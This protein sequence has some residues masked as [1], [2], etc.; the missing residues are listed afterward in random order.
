MNPTAKCQAPR[1]K[2][3]R[4]RDDSSA[5]PL[6]STPTCAKK[7]RREPGFPPTPA[8]SLPG[9]S[10]SPE[11]ATKKKAEK[12][13]RVNDALPFASTPAPS[14]DGASPLPNT[15]TMGKSFK[16]RQAANLT[17]KLHSVLKARAT[18]A[19][20]Q[21]ASKPNRALG[22]GKRRI[23]IGT[24]AAKQALL[25]RGAV[26]IDASFVAASPAMEAD[27]I[28]WVAKLRKTFKEICGE[29][30]APL[31]A[32]ERWLFTNILVSS[33][34]NVNDDVEPFLAPS[35][36]D[37]APRAVLAADLVRGSIPL[38]KANHIVETLCSQ[39]WHTAKMKER[40][41]LSNGH[42]IVTKHK[43]TIDVR[44]ST[45]EQLL[46]LNH[47]HYHKLAA[48]WRL[49]RQDINLV[50]AEPFDVGRSLALP[51]HSRIPQRFQHVAWRYLHTEPS[52][53]QCG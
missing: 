17:G 8:L 19:G 12:R 41:R 47:E 34:Q 15:Q 13:D 5:H 21:T 44:F 14:G 51:L 45:S 31:L 4:D 7:K 20:V 11:G 27:R 1:M 3:K 40:A 26:Y 37:A 48:L 42:V 52:C 33:E 32:F 18:G 38:K 25:S 49:A 29:A 30:N 35:G 10:S 24:E 50:A 28:K 36:K 9:A 6:A 43:H 22:Q 23:W 39:A 16:A 53:W 2:K 46:K